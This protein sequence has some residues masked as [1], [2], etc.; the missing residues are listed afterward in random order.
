[1][2][3]RDNYVAVC[4]KSDRSLEIKNK[5]YVSYWNIIAA[6]QKPFKQGG[7]SIKSSE[8]KDNIMNLI[9]VE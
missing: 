3:T 4:A 7:L 6:F 9:M 2:L 1:M 5:F 8:T